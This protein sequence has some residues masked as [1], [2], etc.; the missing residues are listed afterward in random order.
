MS[1]CQLNGVDFGCISQRSFGSLSSKALNPNSWAESPQL[2]LMAVADQL[3]FRHYFIIISCHQVIM[4]EI[5]SI[6]WQPFSFFCPILSNF[7]NIWNLMA[8]VINFWHL[9]STFGH[10]CQPSASFDN[11]WKLSARF[12]HSWQLFT[13]FS[14]HGFFLTTFGDFLKLYGFFCKYKAIF[15]NICCIFFTLFSWHMSMW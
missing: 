3:D 9:L 13:H 6:F 2:K 15:L 4:F 10:L 14:S 11:P 1:S 12:G 7:D 8:T 5:F